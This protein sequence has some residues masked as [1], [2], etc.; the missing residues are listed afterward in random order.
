[1]LEWCFTIDLLDSD[2]VANGVARG[3]REMQAAITV[4]WLASA[5]AIASVACAYNGLIRRRVVESLTQVLLAL[6]MISAG[7]WVMVDPSGTVGA[8][9]SWANQAGLGT[10]AVSSQGD[11]ANPGRA[12]ASGMGGV[13]AAAI[14][15]PW[16]YLEFGDVD[17]CRNPSRLDPHL[18]AAAMA[19]AATELRSVG[20]A[21]TAAGQTSCGGR[22]DAE[23]R[24]LV[25]SAQLLREART[26]GAIFLAL[27]PNGPARNA[28]NDPASLLRALCRS[29]AA[30]DCHGAAAAQ[31]EF[32]TNRGTWPRVAGLLLIVAGVLGMLLLL[33][34]LALRLLGSAIFSLLYLMLAPVAALAPALGEVGRAAFRKWAAHLLGAVMS[35]LLFAFLLG[36][37]LAILGF[38]EH[39]EALGWW[40]RWLLMSAFW[41]GM[42]A[43]RH[44]ALAL[45][46]GERGSGRAQGF[47]GKARRRAGDALEVSAR[48]QRRVREAKERFS[49][50]AP[51]VGAGPIG[52]PRHTGKTARPSHARHREDGS[53]PGT[54]TP[55]RRDAGEPSDVPATRLRD[56]PELRRGGLDRSGERDPQSAS[57]RDSTPPTNQ[58]SPA[59]GSPDTRSEHSARLEALS[60]QRD[61][62]LEIGN[63]RRAAQLA[64]RARRIEA[65]VRSSSGAQPRVREYIAAGNETRHVRFLSAQFALPASSEASADGPT[66]ERCYPGLAGL[67]GYGRREYTRLDPPSRRAAQLRIDRELTRERAT[68][69][70]RPANLPRPD[71][72]LGGTRPGQAASS[73]S[74]V[75]RDAREIAARRKRQLGREGP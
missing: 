68:N 11:P 65:E 6:A 55:A 4:P 12:L 28:I 29:E 69:A 51:E 43:R 26:N 25:N 72:A 44:Q 35:K 23:T 38:L 42:F 45:T 15:V 60:Q 52:Y 54:L 17:W 30:T 21:D 20:C 27:P 50:R 67:A 34:F 74:V 14:E 37:V 71:M 59:D 18:H 16:C 22:A 58:V 40:T 8:L 63:R 47:P 73:E 75:M 3:L 7:V 5:L 13:F 24:A 10:L 64:S 57:T 33:G 70:G 46:S 2:S 61:R 62:A 41:W 49:K 9:G 31:A 53:A 1:M 48:A 36:V 56:S 66:R 19:L 39:L 32:R